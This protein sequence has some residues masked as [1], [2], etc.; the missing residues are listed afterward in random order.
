MP[1][2]L[3][4]RAKA[5]AAQRTGIPAHRMLISATHSTPRRL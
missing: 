2:E 5:L 4:D 1:R 3:L